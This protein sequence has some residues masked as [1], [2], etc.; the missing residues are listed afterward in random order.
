MTAK[1]GADAL[2]MYEMFM[3]RWSCE[4]VGTEYM[5]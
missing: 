5:V 3:G 4:A 2:R 1:F